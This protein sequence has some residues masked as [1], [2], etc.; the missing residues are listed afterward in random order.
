M[1]A[2]LNELWPFISAALGGVAAYFGAFNA[3]RERMVKIETRQD[4]HD[5]D[6]RELRAALLDCVSRLNRHLENH[7]SHK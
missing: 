6:I 5:N 2:T 7:E 3:M 1:F 4:G